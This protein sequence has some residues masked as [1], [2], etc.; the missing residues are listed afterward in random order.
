M[1]TAKIAGIV[2]LVWQST[3]YVS[4]GH[5]IE[6]LPSLG[7]VSGLYTFASAAIVNT[8]IITQILMLGILM[9]A[10]LLVRDRLAHSTE[11][12]F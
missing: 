4:I 7:N 5:V 11:R 2:A 10:V 6:N 8:E 3:S 12:D 9:L 1:T